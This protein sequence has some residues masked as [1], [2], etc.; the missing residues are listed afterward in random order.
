M[1]TLR[2]PHHAYNV[3]IAAPNTAIDSY[4]VLSHLQ[5]GDVNRSNEVWH[6]A[7]GKGNNM[8]RALMLLGGRPLSVG[9]VGGRSGEFVRDELAREGI[10]F[11]LLW[12]SGATRETFTVAVPGDRQTT[13]FV[14]SGR[15]VDELTQAAFTEKTLACAPQAPFLALTGSLPPGFPPDYYVDVIAR[16][17]GQPV[18]VCVDS[19]GETLRMAA[20]AGAH[21]IKVNLREFRSAFGGQ[22]PSKWD[23]LR[24]TFHRLS[25]RGLELLIVTDGPRGACIVANDGEA[26][27]VT[28]PLESWVSTAG[29]GDTF[30]AALLLAMSRGDGPEAAARYASAAAAASVRQ[31]G[32]GVLMQEDVQRLLG[33]TEIQHPFQ[34]AIAND[35]PMC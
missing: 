35:C 12:T 5:V 7:G 28:T 14:E 21:I 31:V 30:C 3:V 6:A 34:G 10:A 4:C 22:G 8:A 23:D 29:A 19:C 25:R 2:Q 20:E 32:C 1:L 18:K 26:F 13:V 24:T 33:Y 15:P 11:E 16:L 17:R 27:R 9:I